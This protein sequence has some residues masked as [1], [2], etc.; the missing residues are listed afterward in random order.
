MCCNAV[1][2]VGAWRLAG[3]AWRPIERVVEI[4]GGEFPVLTHAVRAVQLEPRRAFG[5][6]PFQAIIAVI[7][8]TPILVQA[9]VQLVALNERLASL[10]ETRLEP[11]Q[12]Q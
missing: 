9:G 8:D 7:R 11:N 10:L 6:N 4:P 3:N 12:L 5:I 1:P 2:P